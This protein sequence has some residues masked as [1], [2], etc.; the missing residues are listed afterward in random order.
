MQCAAALPNSPAFALR[1]ENTPC[2][3]Y[4]LALLLP[5]RMRVHAAFAA[6]D[7]DASPAQSL[8]LPHN[9]HAGMLLLLQIQAH[10]TTKVLSQAQ[11]GLA[12]QQQGGGGG[13]GVP[14][15]QPVQPP[16]AAAVPSN[17]SDLTQR[18]AQ[19]QVSPSQVLQAAST[20]GSTTCCLGT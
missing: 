14:Q 16:G 3:A 8:Q 1:T 15:Q 20:I 2:V 12:Q 7:E 10:L 5:S 17:L 18:F 4:L 19:I 11:A 6:F 9:M 13:G